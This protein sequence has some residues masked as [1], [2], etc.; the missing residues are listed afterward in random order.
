VKIKY[1]SFTE[2]ATYPLQSSQL[3]ECLAS[4]PLGHTWTESELKVCCEELG[5]TNYFCN[6]YENESLNSDCS[7]GQCHSE[8]SLGDQ[9]IA[10]AQD[11]QLA[12]L[13]CTP[14]HELGLV[15]EPLSSEYSTQVNECL[16]K[17]MHN[18]DKYLDNNISV[19]DVLFGKFGHVRCL[20]DK[21]QYS[22]EST[23]SETK[24]VLV[25][26]EPDG[27][28]SH[29]YSM[30]ILAPLDSP[31]ESE[32]LQG[33]SISVGLDDMIIT[34]KCSDLKSDIPMN[35]QY[36]SQHRQGGHSFNGQ[37]QNILE[38]KHL[39]S[40][41][42]TSLNRTSNAIDDVSGHVGDIKVQ[43]WFPDL[44]CKNSKVP[45]SHIYEN[46]SKTDLLLM[47]LARE[48]CN[49][50]CCDNC[51][52][53]GIEDDIN[54]VYSGKPRGE[55]LN[56]ECLVQGDIDECDGS[57]NIQSSG[58]D[59]KWSVSNSHV[60][61]QKQGEVSHLELKTE[62]NSLLPAQRPGDETEREMLEKVPAHGGFE[63]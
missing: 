34:Q 45:D 8:T 5:I 22:S 44:V 59:N 19:D 18:R 62:N 32:M 38:V 3:L 21:S 46:E 11:P 17:L 61:V 2:C 54:T 36:S 57:S 23:H 33:N 26:R 55:L 40:Q 49:F 20:T 10:M 48:Q 25:S 60:N 31:N 30:K 53:V 7:N 58:I 56:L 27:D 41:D 16:E 43:Q 14:S 37:C 63:G 39:C 6:E 47:K 52:V 28:K 9:I 12:E 24:R 15:S 13:S 51:E 35:T 42:S 50:D 29:T 1:S 4:K